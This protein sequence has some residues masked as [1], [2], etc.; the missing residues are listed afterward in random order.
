MKR[1]EMENRKTGIDGDILSGM[2]K[3]RNAV[4]ILLYFCAVLLLSVLIMRFGGTGAVHIDDAAGL[5]GFDFSS[6]IAYIGT[7]CFDCYPGAL[8]TPGDFAAGHVAKVSQA[9]DGSAGYVTYRLVLNLEE[10]TV[11][12]LSGYSATYAQT[13]W[14]DGEIYSSVGTPGDS[15]ENMTPKTNYYTVYFNAESAQTE[16]II[17]R[18]DFVHAAGGELFPLYL[19]EQSHISALTSGMYIRV[20]LMM[21]CVLMAALFFFGIFLFFK[22]RRHF[23]WFSLSCLLMTIRTL[24][25]EYKPI[26]V[27]FPN[28]DWHVVF[29]LE[30]LATIGILIFISLYVNRMFPGK[31]HRAF[32]IL[33]LLVCGIYFAVALLTES[34]TY[35]RLLPYVQ[36]ALVLYALAVI[37]AL[38]GS[39][40]KD[41]KNR[42]LEYF[43]ILFGVST[44]I[45]I[46]ILDL[47]L[48]LYG[49]QYNNVNLAQIGVLIFVFANTLALALNFTR[50]ETELERTRLS[51]HEMAETNRM[52]ERLDKLRKNVL[53]NVSHEMKTPLSSMK[54][55]ALL[56]VEDIDDG[57]VN[58]D[59]RKNMRLLSREAQRLSDLATGLLRI[60]A[61][62][63]T[64][65]AWERRTL[66]LSEIFE[67]AADTCRPIAA[68]NNNR[69]E[70]HI[71][72][73]LPPVR[74]NADMIH[75][76]LLNLTA[77]A[78]RHTRNG[79]ITFS[80]EL[81]DDEIVV[82]VSD[83][84]RGISPELLPHV[85]ERRVS[86]GGSDGLGLSICRDIVEAHG[87]RITIEST[88]GEGTRV[89]F[90]LPV[91]KEGMKDEAD[92][93]DD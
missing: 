75:Q 8:Y 35:T 86:G 31:I 12:G 4:S 66:N 87:G 23:L 60:S 30:Y 3:R 80:A 67:Q 69:L 10:G 26:M 55:Y 33:G 34:T 22:D 89:T 21:G 70:T 54:G 90:T 68:K 64:E 48:H 38:I 18:S 84:G 1:T 40:W 78:G 39:V 57:T 27:L 44:Y 47:V 11:Y 46:M 71:G 56:A 51:E 92:D 36:A 61:A 74:V 43:L 6:G 24:C 37:F 19:G 83:N 63:D 45:V 32:N 14:I 65:M 72:K 25:V 62:A 53:A 82:T 88:P 7:D 73:G 76:V 85:F 81:K 52:L 9:N 58:A 13:L 41:R 59:T 50:I 29:R 17:Q 77:N 91:G 16:I 28:L 5:S 93:T 79:T 15:L 2:K 42:Y 20:S 49:G